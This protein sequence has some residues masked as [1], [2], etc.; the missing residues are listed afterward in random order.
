MLVVQEFPGRP[1]YEPPP[2]WPGPPPPSQEGVTQKAVQQ[3]TSV[4]HIAPIM[5]QLAESDDEGESAD[6]GASTEDG[7]SD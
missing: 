4:A 6:D 5:E 7:E 3:S 1:Q 2:Q